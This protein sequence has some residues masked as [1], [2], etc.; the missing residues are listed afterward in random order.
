M[1]ERADV[2]VVGAG[3]AGLMAA[4]WARRAPTPSRR[5][6][7]LDGARTLGAKILVA[8]GGRCNVTHHAVDETRVRGLDAAGDPQGPAPVRRGG[9]GRV[10]PRAGRRA[11]ARG[12]GQALP[13]HRPGADG[14]GRAAARGARGRASRSAIRGASASRATRGFVRRPH[15]TVR[16]S[17]ADR[18]VLATGGQALPKTGSD[19]AG[20]ELAR[21]LGHTVTRTFPALVPLTLPD[22]HFL[23]TLS[24]LS[25]PATLDGA[26][27]RA[28]GRG[29]H[30]ARAVHA[31]RAL[32]AGGAR[33]QPLLDRRALAATRA[34]RSSRAGCRGRPRTRWT[35][36]CAIRRGRPGGSWPTRLPER[37][38][39]ALCAEAGDVWGVPGP[40][41]HPRG[42]PGA[43]ARGWSSCPCRST[44]DR[45]F[46]EAEATAGGVPLA[47]LR[48]D[49]LESRV[50][51][52][53][54]VCGELCDVDGRIGGFNFQWAW[55]SG[56]VAGTAA[57]AR[58]RCGR[59]SGRSARRPAFGE[60]R[61]Q[62]S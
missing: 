8:G 57:A 52:G 20:Y 51:P 18:V 28:A 17:R 60:E 10:L 12:H 2:V 30:R 7:A 26:R 48:L 55:A 46:T 58:V 23:R 59:Q 3:A 37:L 29:V 61:S 19:G 40:S 45:G 13:H 47:E 33:R 34:P 14:A 16:R 9:H 35:R 44:G 62:P 27:G 36:P 41:P 4:I 22:G 50:T 56:F 1:T 32:G 25:A 49:T 54:Y 24:G 53:L 39:R 6:I 11:E 43:R 21:A 42:A 38:A 31:L 5:V 15:A